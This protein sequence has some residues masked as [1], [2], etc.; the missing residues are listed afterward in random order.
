MSEHNLH[1]FVCWMW[2]VTL[3]RRMLLEMLSDT[4]VFSNVKFVNCVD[5]FHEVKSNRKKKKKK[6]V[7]TFLFLFVSTIQ[8][9]F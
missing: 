7:H 4:R 1:V 3:W 8:N 6:E 9:W 5:P 2:R